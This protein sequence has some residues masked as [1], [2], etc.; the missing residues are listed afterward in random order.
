MPHY[1]FAIF[2][3][4]A[5]QS[6]TSFEIIKNVM[7][8]EDYLK[9]EENLL[10]LLNSNQI[11]ENLEQLRKENSELNGQ[12][13]S[14]ELTEKESEQLKQKI[15]LSK[16]IKEMELNQLQ[17]D[18]QFLEQEQD[19]LKSEK[20]EIQKE[21]KILKEENQKYH[22]SAVNFQQAISSL[23]SENQILKAINLEFQ[24][25]LNQFSDLQLKLNEQ[26]NIIQDLVQK[27]RI[28]SEK[29]DLCQ[30]SIFQKIEI[31]EQE[32]ARKTSEIHALMAEIKTE[33][34][35]NL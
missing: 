29:T 22:Q 5:N 26:E 32:V 9:I 11:K 35:Y 17:K 31:I 2:E 1:Y 8:K 19:K 21:S 15:E 18:I 16:Q 14:L 24:Q 13:E 7:K 27:M 23:N 34:K 25:R 3:F 12:I 6:Q 30:N 10:A 28:Q 20:E 33:D 4:L